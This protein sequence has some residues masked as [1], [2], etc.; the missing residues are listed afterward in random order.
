MQTVDSP[1]EWTSHIAGSRPA[2]L[3]RRV[4]AGTRWLFILLCLLPSLALF[5][6]FVILP[7]VQTMYYSLYKWNGLGPLQDFRSLQNYV[8]LFQDPVFLEAVTHNLIITALSLIT[9]LPLALLL[10]L[11]GQRVPGARFFR[12]V[13]FLP[14]VL[15]DAV[16][17]LIW[18]FVYDPSIGLLS[19]IVKLFN[20]SAVPSALLADTHIVL[21]AIFVVIIWKY[22]G[23]HFV[24]YVAGLQNIPPELAE[25]ARS[26]GANR[27]QV[28]RYVTLPLLG[29]TIRLSAFLSI[30]GSLQYFDLIWVMTSGGPVYASE[31][32]ATYLVHKGFQSFQ[33]GYGSAVGAAIF[34]ICFVFALFYQRWV[35]HQD[36]TGTA[37]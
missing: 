2:H 21:Y 13:F 3:H 23:F 32:M 36:L 14:F 19:D 22:F 5:F 17:G 34:L 1:R 33:L 28:V 15:S 29:S 10:A 31:T 9:Q 8:T 12:L 20:P 25:A 35:M 7:V 37:E 18:S 16:A 4:R 24:L 6:I 11:L 27:W 26:D 30:L